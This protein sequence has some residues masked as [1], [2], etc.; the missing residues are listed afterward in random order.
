MISGCIEADAAGIKASAT[1]KK[2]ETNAESGN[3]FVRA[4]LPGVRAVMN[5]YVARQ[6]ADGLLGK[7]P[8]WPFVDWGKDFENGEAPQEADGQ[9]AVMTLQYV[10]ALRY[11]AELE[12]T[13]GDKHMAEIY[14]GAASRA[15]EGVW[16]LCWDASAGLLADT[17]AK[18]IIRSTRIFWAFGWM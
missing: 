18:D 15:A 5:W 9:S 12:E 11:A 2:E 8:W 7:I 10:E 17:P 4:Q 16:K 6:R 3:E 1:L 13:L 14:R